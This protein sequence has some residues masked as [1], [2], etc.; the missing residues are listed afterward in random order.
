[1]NILVILT[2]GT[3]L[4][5]V[6]GEYIGLNENQGSALLQMYT[7]YTAKPVHFD[8]V[9]PYTILSENL[10]GS[11]IQRLIDC[12]HSYIPDTCAPDKTYDGIIIAHGTDTL[13]YTA[14]GL[15]HEFK[16]CGLP[17]VLVSSN[18]VLEDVRANGFANFAA[19]V[20]FIRQHLGNG[21]YIAYQNNSVWGELSPVYFHYGNRVLPYAVYSDTLHSIN[22]SYFCKILPQMH[23]EYVD[24]ETYELNTKADTSISSPDETSALPENSGILMLHAAPGMYYPNPEKDIKAVLLITYHSGTLPT[25]DRYF[26]DFVQ[27][28]HAMEIPVYVLGAPAVSVSTTMEDM[29]VPECSDTSSDNTKLPYESTARY[30]ELHLKLLPVMSPADAY[31]WLYRFYA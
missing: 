11:H 27:K 7:E 24:Y 15:Y 3:I 29:P 21:V 9:S 1:M 28:A 20:S 2:G 25:D 5:A 26:C 22:D 17:I 23:G 8:C 19:A 30:E 12:I 13:Q 6:S 31:M 16:H 4:S 10:N 18:Y 14:A